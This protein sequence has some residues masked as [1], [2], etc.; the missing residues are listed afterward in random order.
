MKPPPGGWTRKKRSSRS[1]NLPRPNATHLVITLPCCIRIVENHP[2]GLPKCAFQEGWKRHHDQCTTAE[3]DFQIDVI[4]S[5][6]DNS[7]APSGARAV[8]GSCPPCL[9]QNCVRSATNTL[10]WC[11]RQLPWPP[12]TLRALCCGI[13]GEPL[14][15]HNTRRRARPRKR[16]PLADVPHPIDRKGEDD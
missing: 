16:E 11:D 5:E 9:A 8:S 7:N 13:T 10:W 14:A 6:R 4:Q 1:S 15:E 12:A 3:N 2:H